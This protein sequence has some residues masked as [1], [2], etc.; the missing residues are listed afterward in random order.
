[1]SRSMQR[2]SESAGQGRPGAVRP[3]RFRVLMAFAAIYSIWGSTYL[4]IRFAVETLPPFSMTGVRFTIAGGLLYAWA[5]LLRGVSRPSGSHWAAAALVGV[6]MLLFGVGGVSWAEQRISSGAAA[7]LVG[8][9]P[10]FMVLVDWLWY[11]GERPDAKVLA[12][13]VLGFCGVG[14]LVGPEDLAGAGRVDPLGAIVILFGSITWA[15]GSLYTRGSRLPSSP[16][17]ATGME[18]LAG[19]AVLLIVGALVGEWRVLSFSGVASRSLLALVYL[20]IFGSVIA[21]SAY[22][23]LL[24]FVSPSKVITHAYVNP[25]VAVV[26]GWALAGEPL[27]QRTLA[28]TAVIVLGVLVIVSRRE[29]PRAPVPEMEHG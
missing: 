7:L 5:R 3:S 8:V 12:G 13:I 1:M 16:A 29:A 11:A 21:L 6:L 22:L 9:G 4:A 17:L 23:W 2:S 26:L 24:K 19:G 10:L 14:L 27:N 20:I 18:M 25:V 28:A 15:F